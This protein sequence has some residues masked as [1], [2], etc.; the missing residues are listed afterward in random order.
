VEHG[1]A[2]GGSFQLVELIGACGG[3]LHYQLA[4]LGLDLADVLREEPTLDPRRILWLVEHMPSDSAVHA[5]LHGNQAVREWR[6]TEV[7]LA[8][9]F[10]RLAMVAIAA[11]QPHTRRRL[12]TPDPLVPPI[13]RRKQRVVRVIDKLP[14]Q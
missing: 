6:M 7:L 13:G 14:A 10:N 8:G 1:H 11:A 2:A 12:K 3:A 5:A 9:I 4:R